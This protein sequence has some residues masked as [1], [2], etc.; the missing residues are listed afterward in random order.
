[1][2][3]LNCWIILQ[4]WTLLVKWR[5]LFLQHYQDVHVFD[6]EVCAIPI[7]SEGVVDLSGTK[8]VGHVCYIQTLYIREPVHTVWQP[9]V[10]VVRTAKLVKVVVDCGQFFFLL[11]CLFWISLMLGVLDTILYS[12]WLGPRTTAVARG[13]SLILIRHSLQA[14]IASTCT[15]TN[16]SFGFFSSLACG[17]NHFL[18]GVG[19]EG[20]GFSLCS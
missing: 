17:N 6:V 1:M 18:I 10:D 2:K 8:T 13:T 3:H 20:L 19:G 5:I 7:H 4:K 9:E 11:F 16:I 12:Y 14:S 15:C